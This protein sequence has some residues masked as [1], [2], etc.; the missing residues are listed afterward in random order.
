[1]VLIPIP[2]KAATDDDARIQRHGEVGI[3]LLLKYPEQD[4]SKC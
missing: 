4:V 3:V 1:M 2:Q